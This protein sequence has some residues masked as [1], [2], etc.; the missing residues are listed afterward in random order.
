LTVPP[1]I[2][3]TPNCF[4]AAQGGILDLN[5]A[6]QITILLPRPTQPRVLVIDDNP[7]IQQLFER[8]LAP[9]QYQVLHAQSGVD[10]LRLAAETQPT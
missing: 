1:K 5:G 9:Q 4:S 10:A 7:A 8:Y 2:G 3:T 6:G